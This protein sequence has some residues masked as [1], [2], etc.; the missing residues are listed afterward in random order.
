MSQSSKTAFGGMAAALS[1]VL[2]IPTAF[3]LF[4][5]AL[6]AMAGIITMISVI[7]LGR[8]WSFGVYTAVSLISLILVPNKEAV[9]FYIA[10]FGYYPILKSI[11]ESKLPRIIEYI[12]KFL[13][14]NVSAV[15]SYLVLIYALGMPFD[16]LMGIDGDS[17]SFI[18]KFAVP[19][20]LILG[21]IVFITFDFMLT[22]MV[23]TYLR[24]W[25]KRFKKLFPFK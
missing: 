12:L 24:V 18:R 2:L 25:Q 7:E 9:I 1:V 23:G 4:V 16:E 5:Y 15:L 17:S 14:F 22:T 20:M 10:F 13:V 11:L 3:E 6:P 19:I 8:K 21:N